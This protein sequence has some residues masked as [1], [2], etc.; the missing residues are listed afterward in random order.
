MPNCKQC[1]SSFDVTDQDRKHYQKIG[2]PEPTLCPDCR[3]QR[4]ACFRNERNFYHRKCDATGKEMVSMYRPEIKTMVYGPSYWWGDGW[5]PLEYGKDFDFS[6]PFFEQFRELQ[7]VVPRLS[8]YGKAN[9]NSDYTTHTDHA[10]NCYLCVDVGF[11]EDIYYSK[12]IVHCRDLTDCYQLEKSDQCYESCYSVGTHHSKFIYLADGSTDSDF[13]YNCK[14]VKNSLMCWNLRQKQYCIENKQYSKEDY[15]K[16]LKQYDTGSYSNLQKYITRYQE[17]IQ[18]AVRKPAELISCEDC[19]GDYLYNCKNVHNSFSCFD[20]WD[21]RYSYDCCYLRDSYDVYESGFDCEQQYE[22]H[23]CNRGKFLIGCSVCYDVSDLRY[24]EMCHN[25]EYLFG[26]IGLRHKK[27]CILNK[28]YS[29]EEYEKMVPRIIEHMKKTGEWGQFFPVNLSF[30]AYN[31]SAAPEFSPMD[32]EQVLEKGWQWYEDKKAY[33]PQIYEI[34]DHIKEVPD[35]IVDETL[36][37]EDCGKNYRV[38][39][40]ELNFYR[41]NSLPIPHLCPN[42]RYFRR[43]NFRNPYRLYD[44]QCANCQAP[45]QTTYAPDRPEKVLCEKCYLK[46]VY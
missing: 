29:K 31:E 38:I 27:Y 13:L 6:R 42:C 21:A 22:C 17:L 11:A 15:Q 26:C 41:R 45:I 23:A 14:G 7:A 10:K 35:A 36:T 33:Q 24:C 5:D 16:F 43:I 28:Q 34:P 30:F 9:E 19:S 2:V 39:T 3:Q 20:S 18:K 25:S 32:K 12:Y 8:L 46:E 37:C 4:R 40:Q 1:Q 44:R